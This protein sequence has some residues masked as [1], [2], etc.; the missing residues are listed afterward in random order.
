MKKPLLYICLILITSNGCAQTKQT[1]D[2]VQSA[3][4]TDSATN[5]SLTRFIA[6]EYSLFNVDILDNLYLLTAGKQLKKFNASGD[7]VSVYNDVKN[8]G[9]PTSLD[10]TNPFKILLYYKNFS[11]LVVLDRQL[12]LRNS[13]NLRKL[14]IFS[15]KTIAT[16]YDNNIWLFDEQSFKLKK[17]NE[18][19]ETLMETADWRMLYDEVPV[20]S[21]LID[22]NDLVYLYDPEKGF[23]IF[24][25]YGAPK[26]HLPFLNWQNIAVSADYLYGFKEDSL[27]SYRL[28]SLSLNQLRLPDALK[29]AISLK[30]MNGKLYVLKNEGLYIYKIQ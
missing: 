6:G 17:I 30:A 15:T 27:L 1:S 19:G 26:N 2:Q 21:T 14:G 12:S 11:T 5:F 23:Y 20:P 13:I 29:Q 4:A 10:V 24:D 18:E 7:S 16:A 3:A 28:Q 25:Y 8:Y 9:I 22:H